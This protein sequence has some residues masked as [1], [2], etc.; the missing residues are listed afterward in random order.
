MNSGCGTGLM[1]CQIPP[2]VILRNR[3]NNL[4][5]KHIDTLG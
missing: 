3:E 1:A 4:K 2:P 5:H